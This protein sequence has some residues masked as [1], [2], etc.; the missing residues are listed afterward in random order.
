MSQFPGSP[1]V[2][3]SDCLQ[4]EDNKLT[5]VLRPSRNRSGTLPTNFLRQRLI[6]R[7]SVNAQG[8]GSTLSPKI[9]SV[10]SAINKTRQTHGHPRQRNIAIKPV[11]RNQ[12]SLPLIPR[13]EH[14]GRRCTSQN[15]RMDEPG[16]LDVRDVPAGAVDAF[17]VPD[18]F[19]T[20]K[21]RVESVRTGWRK[22]EGMAYAEG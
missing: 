4:G 3:N 1:S 13:L 11:R 16:K 2:S 22:G 5:A 9:M 10:R 15:A 6:S 12:L 17:E 20:G 19:G 8:L 21:G 18:C 7:P 14:F